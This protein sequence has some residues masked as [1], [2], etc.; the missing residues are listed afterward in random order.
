MNGTVRKRSRRSLT[1]V[2]LNR[3]QCERV[4][5]KR[6]IRVFS[7]A[8]LGA[9]CIVAA[10]TQAAAQ[11]TRTDALRDPRSA[12]VAAYSAARAGTEPRAG[13]DSDVDSE[14]L[15]AYPLYRYLQAA[16]IKHALEEVEG[17][18][19]RAD[20]RSAQFLRAHDG[21]PVAW[22]LRQAWLASF[23]RRAQWQSFLEY[24]RADATTPT[25]E[26]LY[27][28]A[29]IQVGAIEG[30]APAIIAEWLTPNR[31]PTECEPVFR[32][33]QAEGPL[34]D[35]LIEQR[36]RLLLGNGRAAFARVIAGRL[37]EKRA[38]PLLEWVDLV[39]TP[40]DAIDALIASPR[41]P[42]EPDA[43][44][45]GFS[46]LATDAPA[47]ARTRYAALV[48]TRNLPDA[49][50]SRLTRA[51]ALGLAWDRRS[52]ALHFFARVA[53]GDVDDYT[54]AWWA[55]AA[56]WSGEW[57]QVADAIARMS[58]AQ[59]GESAWRYWAARAAGQSQADGARALYESLLPDDNYYSAM[60]AARLGRDVTP[61]TQPLRHDAGQVRRIAMQAPF[62][63]AKELLA[64]GMR[65]EAL[66]EWRYGLA[67]LP[68]GVRPQ[69]VHLAGQWGWHDVAVLTATDEQVFYDYR[70][71]YPE[72]YTRPVAEAHAMTRL[73]AP[74]I[75][76]LLRQESLFNPAAVSSA[77]A[78]GL[79][80]LLPDTARRVAAAWDEPAPNRAA[81]LEPAVNIKLGAA[82]LRA[83]IDAFDGQIA[84]GLAAYNAGSNNV[85]HWLSDRPVDADIWI[86]N[87][88]Y[89]ETRAYVRRVL[90][91]SLVF[92]WL[93]SGRPQ[94]ARS[95]LAP[96]KPDANA[97]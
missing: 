68:A 30:L 88:P 3:A 33:L 24:Y 96:I 51:L 36:V 64:S 22:P 44:L 71:L 41:D 94:N 15:R 18:W 28:Q 95:W 7:P 74:L 73:D 19:Q 86:E 20:E 2:R 16:R 42:V 75:Y 11:Q 38:A 17:E 10:A 40:V 66:R 67:A 62:V 39:S 26:C 13:T 78:L 5:G 35:E 23:A 48:E 25:L 34:T 8:A 45:A 84:P 92:K 31:L 97:G 6:G 90:W 63:R 29:R 56:L 1:G 54:L 32:W 57:R 47:A 82:H 12:F 77:G 69:S 65:I 83:L 27:L 55:R 50:V 89:N 72:P 70:L 91:H 21:E 80:Q 61:H 49:E 43:L 46:R 81:L 14:S 85:E 60:A 53:P 4:S 76:A 93:D 37:P 87:I 58:P 79:A 59:R 52:A 9:V